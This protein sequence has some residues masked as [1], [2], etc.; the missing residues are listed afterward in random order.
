MKI[1]KKT[2]PSLFA[3]RHS[4]PRLLLMSTVITALLLNGCVRTTKCRKIA[5]RNPQR[6]TYAKLHNY[7][8]RLELLTSRR[9]FYAGEDVKFTYRLTNFGKNLLRI[10]EWY[11][12]E[13]DNIRLYYMPDKAPLTSFDSKD[14]ILLEPNYK[15]PKNRFELVLYPKNSVLID[16]QITFIKQAGADNPTV[17]RGKYYLVAELTLNS[18]DVR[19]KPVIIEI[20]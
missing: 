16:K 20:P 1:L 8:L 12:H 5:T 19:S 10:N 13:P 6:K 9:R 18:V 17:K 3:S 7:H 2:Y 15:L 14:W 4:L 11:M